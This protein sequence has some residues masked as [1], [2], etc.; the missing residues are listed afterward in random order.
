MSHV[1]RSSFVKAILNRKSIFE[2]VDMSTLESTLIEHH[3][4]ISLV[5]K[6]A[7]M[8][9][10]FENTIGSIQVK[11]DS[12][13]ESFD[14]ILSIICEHNIALPEEECIIEKIIDDLTE[15]G[16]GIAPTNSVSGIE[17][18]VPRIGP[19]KKKIIEDDDGVSRD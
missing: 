15:D 3:T 18:N 6:L 8:M 4:N 14:K 19:K 9:M 7:V 2:C 1:N 11:I 10:I 16:E 17:P 5:T 12:I 13:N